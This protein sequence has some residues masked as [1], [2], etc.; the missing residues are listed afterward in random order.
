MAIFAYK[1]INER[2]KLVTGLVD[3]VS[4]D[5]VANLLVEKGFK[6]VEIKEKDDKGSKFGLQ[7]F[8]RVGPKDLVIFFRQLSLMIDSSLP[9]V[10]ALRILTKQASS[11]NLK[12]VVSG[13]A[14]EVDG[15]NSLSSAMANYSNAFSNFQINIVKSG[16]T[17]GRLGEVVNY[18]ADQ[19]EKDYDLRAKVINAMIYPAIII[20][21]LFAAGFIL[22]TFVMPQLASMLLASGQKLPLMTQLLINV[23]NIFNNYWW[24]ILIMIFTIP[25]VI[26]SLIK[27]NHDIRRGVDY[28]VIKV[29]IFG[30][31]FQK[32][33]IIRICRSLG[34]LLKGGVPMAQALE[35]V[36][37]VAD[38]SVYRDSL[39]HAIT[40]VNEG[41]ALS[42]SIIE[43]KIF[44]LMVSQMLSVGEETGRLD[45]VL[46]KITDFYTKE[47]TNAVSNLTVL[48]EPLI[49]IVLGVGVG[50]FIT[51]VIV[52]MWQLAGSY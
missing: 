12:S 28:L 11:A 35:V 3:A 17:S 42:E 47:V 4:M 41:M 30:A 8:N 50:F 34:T 38:N 44:P 5:L 16:E 14:D 18:L 49:M 22:M 25:I 1:A 27:K 40:E 46:D 20:L 48:I 15:G 21:G 7:I 26:F 9:I 39:T 31:I 2:N 52:P 36:R 43:D 13:V 23:A 6:I 37:E 32:I 33:Y 10:R 24:L 45:D 19:Q 29:P 51:A